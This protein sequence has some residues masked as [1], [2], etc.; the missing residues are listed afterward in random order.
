MNMEN[1]ID[2]TAIHEAGH[3]FMCSELGFEIEK[4]TIIPD[5]AKGTD[6][7]VTRKVVPRVDPNDT[8]Q[9]NLEL[10]KKEILILLSGYCALEIA[11][12]KKSEDGS[13]RDY[14]KAM[15]VADSFYDSPLKARRLIKKC[16]SQ[17]K[18]I[19]IYHW[20]D[21][22]AIANEL[23]KKQVLVESDIKK[24]LDP[25]SKNPDPIWANSSVIKT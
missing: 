19:L 16:E 20:A 11:K 4:A 10:I 22:E 24:M 15:V 17:V 12:A 7:S 23:L 13:A 21:V 8:S 14:G 18:R 9:A 5:M 6:G 1:E 3:I 2:R 25:L